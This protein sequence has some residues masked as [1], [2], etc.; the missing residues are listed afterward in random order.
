MSYYNIKRFSLS[1][2][3]KEINENIDDDF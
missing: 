1:N 2:Q 3:A